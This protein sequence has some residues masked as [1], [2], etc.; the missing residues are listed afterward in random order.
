MPRQVGLGEVRRLIDD[1][2]ELVEVLPAEEYA[3]EHLP[4]SA[5]RS[6]SWTPPPPSGW[7]ARGR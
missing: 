6:S 5:S 2:A 1:G 4:P 3:E 7:I